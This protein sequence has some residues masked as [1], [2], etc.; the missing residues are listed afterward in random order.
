MPPAR[1][2][3]RG[4]KPAPVFTGKRVCLHSSRVV[5]ASLPWVAAS[6][7]VGLRS[8]E[9]GLFETPEVRFPGTDVTA[10]L[11]N[12]DYG[13]A[14]YTVRL[15]FA[16]L[17][18][19]EPGRRV[20]D[21]AVAGRTVLKDFDIAREAGGPLKEVVREIKGIRAG[22]TLTLALTPTVGEPL[23]CGVEL[24]AEDAGGN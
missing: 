14:S 24:V 9:I 2:G 5:E 4:K 22:Q 11:P 16:E 8:L 17:E 15:Y 1:N 19:L 6:G 13:Q 21:V 12:V 20:F 10:V 18:G 7:L 3:D 23:L